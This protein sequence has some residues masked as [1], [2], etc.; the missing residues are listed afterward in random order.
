MRVAA[1]TLGLLLLPAHGI[2]QIGN[3]AG[4]APD[5]LMDK[6]GGPAANQTNYQD[7]LSARLLTAGG[8]AEVELGKLAGRSDDEDVKQFAD[9]MV[10]VHDKANEALKSIAAKSKIP[11]PGELDP[12]HKKIK[13]DLEKLKGSEF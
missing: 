8:L 9:R 3:P 1:I 7:R 10:N 6:P 12:D 2:A 11:L 13:A 4:F 5:T